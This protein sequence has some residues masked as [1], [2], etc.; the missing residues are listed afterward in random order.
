LF[1]GTDLSITGNT[2][3]LSPAY[4]ASLGFSVPA[5]IGAKLAKPDL[6]PIVLVGD[7]AFQMTGMELSTALRYHIN[8]IVIVLNNQGYVTEWLLLDGP[9]DNLQVWRYSMI[10]EILGGGR[11]FVVETED[12][13]EKTLHAAKHY[14]EEFSIWM[15]TWIRAINHLHFNA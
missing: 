8:P 9:F 4:Y 6:R 5:R 13:L 3:F 10:P 15:S 7:G 1:A 11:G 12:Q 14:I 2:Q